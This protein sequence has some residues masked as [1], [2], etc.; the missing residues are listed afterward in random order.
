MSIREIESSLGQEKRL[1]GVRTDIDALLMAAML[2]IGKNV[3][4]HAG[5]NRI[6][7]ARDSLIKYVHVTRESEMQFPRARNI[8]ILFR[9]SFDCSRPC[10]CE[11]FSRN[12]YFVIVVIVLFDTL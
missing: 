3:G 4:R 12:F 5:C 1:K 7:E 10:R 2:R 6:N 9:N 11:E 8:H